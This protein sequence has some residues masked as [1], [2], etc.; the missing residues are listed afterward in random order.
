MSVPFRSEFEEDSDRKEACLA[1]L[2]FLLVIH[3][4]EGGDMFL[5]VYHLNFG[6]KN[7]QNFNS[8]QNDVIFRSKIVKLILIQ[9]KMFESIHE[10][11]KYVRV[12]RQAE[13]TIIQK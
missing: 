3:D 8:N 6:Q 5:H 10:K 1:L 2:A 7:C 4:S 9:Q 12:P 13:H 11:I